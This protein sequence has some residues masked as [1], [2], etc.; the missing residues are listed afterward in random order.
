M[1]LTNIQ[2]GYVMQFIIDVYQW[3][4]KKH[5]KIIISYSLLIVPNVITEVNSFNL[6]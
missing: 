5:T 4:A 6:I 3:D 1:L 2:T